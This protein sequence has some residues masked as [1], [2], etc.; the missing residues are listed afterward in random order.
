MRKIKLPGTNFFT[1]TIFSLLTAVFVALLNILALRAVPIGND[2]SPNVV[3]DVNNFRAALISDPDKSK[4]GDMMLTDDQK[5]SFA[6]VDFIKTFNQTTGPTEIYFEKLSLEVD[7]DRGD[8][9]FDRDFIENISGSTTTSNLKFGYKSDYSRV[10]FCE[11]FETNSECELT[12]RNANSSL[13]SK[14]LVINRKMADYSYILSTNRIGS[15]SDTSADIQAQGE[16][17]VTFTEL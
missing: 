5:S 4:I 13:S 3:F 8:G 14:V 11:K 6:N 15:G 10:K 2:K 17:R 7:S 12:L 9:I 16:I 1:I